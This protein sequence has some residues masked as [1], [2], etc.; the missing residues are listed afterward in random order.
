MGRD[1]SLAAEFLKE[2]V[3]EG[4]V[5]VAPLRH[6]HEQGS[7]RRHEMDR[8]SHIH[9]DGFSFI[10]D[11]DNQQ[12]HVFD[13]GHSRSETPNL[14]IFR[15]PLNSRAQG[16]LPSR[17]ER[18]GN[19]V[20]LTTVTKLEGLPGPLTSTNTVDWASGVPVR[21]EQLMNQETIQESDY[22]GITTFAGGITFPQ[23]AITT[24][25]QGGHV[26]SMELALLES[27]RFNEP[28]PEATFL[29][30]K[31]ESWQVLDFRGTADGA[32]FPVPSE[33]VAD[34]RTLIH[35]PIQETVGLGASLLPAAKSTSPW[36]R[37]LLILNGIALV[38]FGI[39]MWK[40]TSLKDSKD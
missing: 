6:I 26:A 15:V 17:A 20:R 10:S 38:G 12:I 27:A 13:P 30:A 28:I 33:A 1:A 18:E 16:Y 23:C 35:E 2:V 37:V 5:V 9:V 24:R 22:S 34:V 40:R 21:R 39:W 19:L 8:Y 14:R 11:G 31:P 7:E 32:S 25:Y 36:K 29:V 3:S 4:R